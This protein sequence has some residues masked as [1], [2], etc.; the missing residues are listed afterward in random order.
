MK[1]GI[2][3]GSTREGRNG[4]AVGKW[5]EKHAADK[6]GAEYELIDLKSF[7]LPLFT[8]ETLPMMANKQYD[9]EAVTA[10]S[11]AIDACDGFIFVTPEYNHG[12]PAPLKNAVDSLG[13]EWSNKASAFVGYGAVGGVR[14]VEQWRQIMPNFSQHVVRSA[15]DLNLFTDFEDAGVVHSDL[16][17]KSLHGMLDELHAAVRRQD[18]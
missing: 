13:S 8:S 15:V 6:G 11:R 16:K 2:I 3:I 7:D 12:V 14:A 4:E 17:V 5:V 18:A 10:W 9:S 1:I